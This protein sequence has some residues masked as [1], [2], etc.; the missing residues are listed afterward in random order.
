ML[1]KKRTSTHPGE[2]LK[3]EF[4]DALGLTQTQLAKHLGSP[5]QRVNELVRGKEALPQIQRGSYL[6]L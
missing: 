6:R 3:Y 5:I 4:I 2:E 1:P